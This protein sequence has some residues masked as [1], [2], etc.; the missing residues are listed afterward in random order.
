MAKGISTSIKLKSV[1]IFFRLKKPVLACFLYKLLKIKF[2]ATQLIKDLFKR[3]LAFTT[4]THL[5]ELKAR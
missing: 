2:E 4:E 1:S 3:Q 5:S